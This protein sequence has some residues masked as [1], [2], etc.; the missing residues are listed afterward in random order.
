MAPFLGARRREAAAEG[1]AMVADC[2]ALTALGR[3]RPGPSHG[4]RHRGSGRGDA[5][6]A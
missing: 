4:N 1:E 3:V 5:R 6:G 2:E